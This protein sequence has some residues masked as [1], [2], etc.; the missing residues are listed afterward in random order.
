MIEQKKRR[1]IGLARIQ[2]INKL[3]KDFSDR[4][5]S[6]QAISSQRFWASSIR[7]WHLAQLVCMM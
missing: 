6:Q 3:R 7:G 4:T 5:D 2:D 1:T